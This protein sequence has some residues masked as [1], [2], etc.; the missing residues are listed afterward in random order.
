MQVTEFDT[1]VSKVVEFYKGF[2]KEFNEI[3]KLFDE[4]DE[5]GGYQTPAIGA[6][7]AKLQLYHQKCYASISVSN[8]KNES[9]SHILKRSK[10]NLSLTELHD[11]LKQ[12]QVEVH[13]LLTHDLKW[14]GQKTCVDILSN[15]LCKISSWTQQESEEQITTLYSVVRILRELVADCALQICGI[16]PLTS[17]NFGTEAFALLSSEEQ[18]ILL[19][20]QTIITDRMYFSLYSLEDLLIHVNKIVDGFQEL[21]W[22]VYYDVGFLNFKIHKYEAARKY[23]KIVKAKQNLK[24]CGDEMSEKKYFHAILLIAYS[25]EYQGK[26]SN[27]ISALAISPEK[28]SQCLSLHTLSSISSDFEKIFNE[29]LGT[30]LEEKNDSL[31]CLYFDYDEILAHGLKSAIRTSDKRIEILHALAHCLN[32]F[33]IREDANG[34]IGYHKFI[35]FAREMMRYI[36]NINVEYWT[37]YATIHGEYTDFKEAVIQLDNAESQIVAHSLTKY[38]TPEGKETLIAEINFF[39]YYFNQ[40]IGVSATIEKERFEQYCEKYSD[41]DAEC[42]IKI[43]EFRTKLREYFSELFNYIGGIIDENPELDGVNLPISEDLYKA[44]ENLCKLSPTL[45]MNAN[46]KAE[47]RLMQRAFVCIDSL[48]EYILHKTVDGYLKVI[49]ACRRFMRVH[50]EN[51]SSSNQENTLKVTSIKD[52][53]FGL[54][55]CLSHCLYKSDSIFILAPISG[56]V[57]YQYQT[58]TINLLFDKGNLLP[59]NETVSEVDWED[60]VNLFVRESDAYG[61]PKLDEIDWE[62]CP[63]NINHVFYWNESAPSRLIVTDTNESF[64]RRIVDDI[65]FANKIKNIVEQ[66]KCENNQLCRRKECSNY[67]QDCQVQKIQLDWLQIVNE[68]NELEPAIIYWRNNP[69]LECFIV[70]GASLNKHEFHLWIAKACLSFRTTTTSTD[71]DYSAERFRILV[72]AKLSQ[73]INGLQNEIDNLSETI[74]YYEG[75]PDNENLRR[76]NASKEA[77]SIKKTTL[78]EMLKELQETETWKRVPAQNREQYILDLDKKIRET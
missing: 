47:L 59:Q 34:S 42:H 30:I 28:I 11:L 15:I 67:G 4:I 43:F 62:A 63:E 19:L 8:E 21:H 14:S 64:V 32:E 68:S 37:C 27:A 12:L 26:F 54:R 24:S 60:L 36:A 9:F 74:A 75:D 53:F 45:Y 31:L 10:G 77:L 23:F 46:V 66:A 38:G 3:D 55:G 58:G 33:A 35:V 76:T 7:I 2:D 41:D 57:V 6:I 22:L 40:M 72:I 25:Y 65:A 29:I 52:V 69:N 17:W 51:K 49:N 70:K 56:S 71:S 73:A 18:L 13:D 1:T 61:Q 16:L 78:E 39:R 20:N 44:Y 5:R 50:E 48:R